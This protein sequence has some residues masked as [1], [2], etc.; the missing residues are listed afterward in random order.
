[1]AIIP[2]AITQQCFLIINLCSITAHF[3]KQV[4]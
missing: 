3:I 1:M 4:N 2:V